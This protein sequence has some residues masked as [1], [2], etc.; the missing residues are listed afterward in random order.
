MI[1]FEEWRFRFEGKDLDSVGA[2]GIDGSVSGVAS[3]KAGV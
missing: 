2:G 3:A 1:V